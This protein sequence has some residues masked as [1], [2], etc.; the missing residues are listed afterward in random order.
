MPFHY[1]R[2]KGFKVRGHNPDKTKREWSLE[3]DQISKILAAV[4]AS[5]EEGNVNFYRDATL[6]S[7]AFAL[8]LRVGE[9][10]ILE[11][12][13][14]ANLLTNDCVSIPTLKNIPR[15]AFRC[16]C[17]KQVRLKQSRIGKE[18]TCTR[19]RKTTVV[20]APDKPLKTEIPERDL[21]FIESDTIDLICRTSKPSRRS[22]TSSSPERKAS[23]CISSRRAGYSGRSSNAPGCPI[24]S[25]STPCAT[26]AECEF[27]GP[28]GILYLFA[29]HYA[30]V[31]WKWPRATPSWMK[32]LGK[33]P[34]RKWKSPAR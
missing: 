34:R 1:I 8:G 29:I 26:A 20:A 3:Q 17:G 21:P 31:A 22:K 9:V 23:R 11:R 13:H 32:T 2:N 5:K 30:T 14:F 12:H 19:C 25:R 4:E 15:V 7:L 10:V 33:K 24:N 27:T 18:F 28:C 6:I 16:D